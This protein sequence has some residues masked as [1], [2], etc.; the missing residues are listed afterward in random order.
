MH[1][2]NKIIS[3][4]IASP[5]FLPAV[6]LAASGSGINDRVSVPS[7]AGRGI[8]FRYFLNI[9]NTIIDY[10]FTILL[11]LSVVFILLAAFKYLTAG[12]DEEKIGSAHKI[13]LW[14]VVAIAVALL[15]QGVIFLVQSIIGV[16][17]I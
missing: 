6:T 7:A 4:L 3:L 13:L 10:L 11:V 5:L 15:S 9:V 12:G 2:K 1:M 8:N 16:S 14:A 17:A